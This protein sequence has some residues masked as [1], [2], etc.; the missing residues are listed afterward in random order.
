MLDVAPD[1]EAWSIRVDGNEVVPPIDSAA[2]AEQL[3][4][5]TAEALQRSGR[6]AAVVIRQ[7]DGSIRARH[8]FIYR[9][10][11]PDPSS[12]AQGVPPR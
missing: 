5:E 6:D 9:P 8:D 1:G 3:A 2:A 10:A 4:M 7:P 11:T 12:P